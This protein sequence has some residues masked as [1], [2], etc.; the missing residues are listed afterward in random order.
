MNRYLVVTAISFTA[1]NA[2]ALSSQAAEQRQRGER[3]EV[4]QAPDTAPG[5]D[6]GPPGER[7]RRRGDGN[8]APGGAPPGQPAQPPAA[9]AP[10]PAAAAPPPAA[11]APSGSAAPP[12]V[13]PKRAVDAGVKNAAPPALLRRV[14]RQRRLGHNKLSLPQRRRRRKPNLRRLLP[15]SATRKIGAP[16]VDA[17]TTAKVPPAARR[18]SSRCRHPRLLALSPLRLR[19]LPRLRLHPCS[20]CSRLQQHRLPLRRPPTTLIGVAA[21]LNASAVL[22]LRHLRRSKL[23]LRQ[24]LKRRLRQHLKRR[25][26]QHPACNRAR[27]GARLPGASAFPGRCRLSLELQALQAPRP[28]PARVP[29]ANNSEAV[30]APSTRSSAADVSA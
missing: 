20:R 17:A 7:R 8:G 25:L 21:A 13:R 28:R 15:H 4:A 16:A 6:E 18:R 3:L 23:S 10:P 26:R 14:S 2:V 11:A 1:F 29:D 9:G 5:T 30:A 27:P 19:R 24:H 22:L 12:A